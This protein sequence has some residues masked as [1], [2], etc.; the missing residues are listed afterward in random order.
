MARDSRRRLFA[1]AK[2]RRGQKEN[3]F[4]DRLR[5][6]WHIP[7][8]WNWCDRRRS[9]PP[10]M[11]P[12]KFMIFRAPPD[13]GPGA[14]FRFPLPEFPA[15]CRRSTSSCRSQRSIDTTNN[16]IVVQDGSTAGGWA[17]AKLSEVP[18]NTSLPMT[19]ATA[20]HGASLQFGI[21]ETLVTLAGA[22]V[23]APTQ[24]PANS[25]VFSVGAYVVSTITGA[26]SY[27]VG[28]SGNLGQFG[29]GL[30]LPTGS[31]NFGA[32]GPTVFYAPTPLIVTA[33][34]SNF[35]GGSVRLSIHYMVSPPSTS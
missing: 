31:S 3:F 20:S 10:P 17:A 21:L 22:S 13:R 16:R 9:R 25:C 7:L 19:L 18:I 26:A 11:P 29:S 12:A 14:Y 24:I 34:G 15:R 1:Q 8:Q 32:I 35:T 4:L 23:T 2:N 28:V 33:L 30:S 5:R 27:E 6:R